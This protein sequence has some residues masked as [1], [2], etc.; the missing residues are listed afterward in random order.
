MTVAWIAAFVLLWTEI[1]LC[2]QE[3]TLSAARKEGKLVLYT[4][5]QPEDSTK[6]LDLYR[7]RYPFVEASFFRAG[8]APL[9]NRIL[10]ETRAQQFLFDVV[11]GKISD[12]LLLQKEGLLRKIVSAQLEAYPEKFKDPRGQWVD[13]YNNYYTIAYNTTHVRA[14]DAPKRWD[15][16]LDPR[17]ADGKIT[18]DPRSYDWYFGMRSLLGP[19]KAKDFMRK[20]S[21]QKPAFRDGNVLIAN[22]LAAGEFPLAITYAHL[23]ER[24]RLRGAPVDWVAVKPM[25]AVPISMALPVR[26]SHPNAASLFLDLALSKEGGELLSAMGRVSTRMDVTPSAERLNPKSLDLIPLRASSD[27]MDPKEF[28]SVLGV[29]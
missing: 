14:A 12:L 11:S 6:L 27:E 22:L 3:Q 7:S 18:L 8:S 29:R 23:V 25:V 19:E 26:S 28:R 1:V 5:M 4:A 9:L 21:G 10:T 24:L 16:L 2:A 15:E 20:L 13:I 17:W